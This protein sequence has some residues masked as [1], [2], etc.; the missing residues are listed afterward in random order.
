MAGPSRL[1]KAYL[2]VR[3]DGSKVNTDLA[4]VRTGFK[5]SLGRMGQIAGGMLAF[6]GIQAGIQGVVTSIRGFITA[7]E[8]F[9]QAMHSSLA[10]MGDVSDHMQ[11]KMA[12]AAKDVAANTVFSGKEAAGAYFY[13]ASAGMD[14]KQSIAALPQVAAFAQAGM[15]NLSTATDLLTDAQSALGLSTKDAQVN[16]E[17]LT[18]V[19]DVLV[20]ANTLANA[21][22]EQFSTALTTKSAAALRNVGK[23][24]EEGTAVLAAFADQGIKG[25]VGGTALAIVLR[26]LQTK[27]LANKGA[28]EE[29]GVAVYD[30]AGKMNNMADIVGQLEVAMAGLS[31]EQKKAKLLGMGFS[32]KSVGFIQSL[33]G[34]SGKIKAYETQLRKAGGTTK[35][36]ADKQLPPLTKAWNQLKSGLESVAIVFGPILTV[37]AK[38]MSWAAKGFG[39][40]ASLGEKLK[41]A[42]EGAIDPAKKLRDTIAGIKEEIES[43]STDKLNELT[44]QLQ[45]LKLMGLD[46]DFFGKKG[47]AKIEKAIAGRRKE[48]KTEKYEEQ[49]SLDKKH[50]LE[51][52][53]KTG[54][55]AELTKFE[56]KLGE[57]YK[58]DPETLAEFGKII[59]NLWQSYDANAAQ[60]KMYPGMSDDAID[61]LNASLVDLHKQLKD[62]IAT[63]GMDDYERQLNELRQAGAPASDID[64]FRKL[65]GELRGLEAGKEATRKQDQKRKAD[66]QE[67]QRLKNSLMTPVDKYREQIKKLAGLQDKGLLA[68]GQFRA[69]AKVAREDVLRVVKDKGLEQAGV[70]VSGLDKKK[71]AKKQV[72]RIT[73]S[74]IAEFAQSIQTAIGSPEMALQRQ[75]DKKLGKANE[76]LGKID[77]GIRE[78]VGGP[79]RAG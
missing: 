69:L 55:A 26:D 12:Q 42:F 73:H 61:K 52:N 2:E 46:D 79:A 67:A 62:D 33:M 35:E 66:S 41:D 36:V 78:N 68:G 49:K 70:G 75:M 20:K 24:I 5:A 43:F 32:D 56:G 59:K 47:V 9:N 45:A 57:R 40:L 7:S 30:S 72:G 71:E 34:T 1:A 38:L 13:L 65:F 51:F 4:K 54:S 37:L 60:R 21:S 16:L 76:L 15:F 25:Q 28:F 27:A 44:Q 58:D 29:A 23:E 10:I 14:A 39:W 74:G 3:A 64:H 6:T 31:D 50:L 77:E 18:R 11:G 53:A 22:V 19:S 8:G 48:I 63:F 17:N